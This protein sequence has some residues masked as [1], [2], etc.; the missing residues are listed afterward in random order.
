MESQQRR[1]SGQG[2]IIKG[3]QRYQRKHR[4][5]KTELSA[6]TP[7]SICVCTHFPCLQ[8]PPSPTEST[9]QPFNTS[10]QWPPPPRSPQAVLIASR[11]A[12]N[13]TICSSTAGTEQVPTLTWGLLR[14]LR[15]IKNPSAN[16]GHSQGADS[17][18][19]SGR[20]LGGGSDSPLQYSCLGNPMDRG[21][22]Q[23]R[24]QLSIHAHP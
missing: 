19:G 1:H 3:N 2:P 24:T 17:T 8:G 6:Y 20:S 22:W 9:W 23:A 12:H 21:A 15:G 10:H 7:W 18:P 4:R 14:R 16:P 5:V 13:Y 11:S